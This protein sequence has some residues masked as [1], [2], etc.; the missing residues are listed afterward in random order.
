MMKDEYRLFRIFCVVSASV[1]CALLLL[2]GIL[3]AKNKTEQTVLGKPY[4]TLKI[5]EKEEGTVLFSQG[6][7]FNVNPGDYKEAGELLLRTV[8]SPISNIYDFT[9]EIIYFLKSS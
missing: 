4:E 7:I 2:T 6:R 8:F 5:Y 9:Q 1:M 3:T